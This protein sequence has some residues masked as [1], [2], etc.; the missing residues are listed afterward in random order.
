ME[1]NGYQATLPELLTALSEGGEAVVIYRNVNAVSSFQ[2]AKD[3]PS[4]ARSTRCS[5]GWGS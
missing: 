4:S 1:L 5:P 2:H 3:G